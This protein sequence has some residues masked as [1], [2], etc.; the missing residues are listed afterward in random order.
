MYLLF[1]DESGK[2]DDGVFALGGVSIRADRW[3]GIRERWHDCLTEA[4]W[5]V[6]KELKWSET[7]SGLVPPDVADAAYACLAELDVECFV[8]VLWTTIPGHEQLFADDE[9]TYTTAITFIAE[10]FNRSLANRDSY[11]AIVLDSRRSEED[12]RMRR[13]FTDIQNEGTPFADLD[14][15][16]DGLMLGPSHFSLGL[17]LADLVVGPTRAAQFDSGDGQRRLKQLMSRF[18]RNPASGEVDGV[19]LKLFP[20]SKTPTEGSADRLFNPREPDQ[21]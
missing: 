2:P 18:A 20:F 10:R 7:Q 9:T 8:T 4:G 19:G 11:G 13:F 6:E 12:D 1:L 3:H 5:P 14:R 15:I 21:D 17:Q 16:V